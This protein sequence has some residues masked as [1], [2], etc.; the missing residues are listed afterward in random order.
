[1]CQLVSTKAI[2][3]S[4]F[5]EGRAAKL[6]KFWTEGV[7]R[8]G[9][10]LRRPEQVDKT[11]HPTCTVHDHPRLFSKLRHD[12]PEQY[13]I[14]LFLNCPADPASGRRHSS[15]PLSV[16]REWTARCRLHDEP[17]FQCLSAT[18]TTFQD[19]IYE[20]QVCTHMMFTPYTSRW[21]RNNCSLVR[22][23]KMF[24]CIP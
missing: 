14:L 10:H 22:D 3:R 9:S 11:P 1:M 15:E 19:S 4:G 17:P 18:M 7:R 8:D 2:T 6:R 24:A 21:T 13:Q 23:T 16:A 20:S 12:L 5:A